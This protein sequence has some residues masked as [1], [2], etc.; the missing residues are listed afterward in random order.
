LHHEALEKER[1][2]DS[3]APEEM[4]NQFNQSEIRQLLVAK[5]RRGT[6]ALV[7]SFAVVLIF[8]DHGAGGGPRW[9]KRKQ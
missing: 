6:A 2:E 9:R 7:V 8:A 4:E 5:R 3:R 1:G